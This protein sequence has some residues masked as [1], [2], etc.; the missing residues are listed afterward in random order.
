MIIRTELRPV[1]LMPSNTFKARMLSVTIAI[2]KPKERAPLSMTFISLKK[3]SVHAK[4]GRKK[5]SIKPRI[6]LMAGNFSRK[7]KINS[8]ICLMGDN[9]S[10]TYIPSPKYST[11]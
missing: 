10:I 4:P 9:Q 6:A 5:T 7:G 2:D 8:N 1:I 3:T 11:G